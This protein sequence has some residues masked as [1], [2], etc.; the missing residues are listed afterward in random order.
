M[1]KSSLPLLLALVLL[2]PARPAEPEPAQKGTPLDASF[3]R[4]YAETR[5]FTLGRPSRPKPTPDGKA[6]L[7]LRAEAKEDR[8]A[9]AG[10]TYPRPPS[11][12]NRLDASHIRR[13]A[14]PS[15]SLCS[16]TA[17]VQE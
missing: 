12:P 3:L 4:L 8:T 1:T 9:H 15:Q 14:A 16:D 11:R 2:P 10:P 13:G 5:G 17:R 6:I 7:F